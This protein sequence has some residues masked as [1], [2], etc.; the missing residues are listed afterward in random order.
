MT[1]PEAALAECVRVW[2]QAS[3]QMHRICG[4][5]D[6]LY[7]HAIQPNQYDPGAKPLTTEENE[8]M[9]SSLGRSRHQR[10]GQVIPWAYPLLRKSADELR[11]L[12]VRTLDLTQIFSQTPKTLYVDSCCHVNPTGS[13]MLASSL[14]DFVIANLPEKWK[15]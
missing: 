12:G 1:S 3:L 6:I 15:Q 5:S 10:Y 7:V 13:E 11:S 2:K 4:A 9:H 14:A 8:L